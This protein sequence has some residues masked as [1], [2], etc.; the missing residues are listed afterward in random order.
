MTL[1]S[2]HTG[3][4]IDAITLEK[5]KSL[6]TGESK[7]M[8]CFHDLR[9]AAEERT[10]AV[11]ARSYELCLKGLQQA[12]KTIRLRLRTGGFCESSYTLPYEKGFSAD[13]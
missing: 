6:I 13:A 1:H 8:Q 11:V 7:P 12:G 5:L 3:G 2:W 9:R 4:L 10:T